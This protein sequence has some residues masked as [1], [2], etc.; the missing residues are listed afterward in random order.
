M[1]CKYNFV[2]I[3]EKADRKESTKDKN[4]EDE[5]K[6][7]DEAGKDEKEYKNDL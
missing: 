3:G 7:K 6:K 1:F 2:L 4:F 5:D